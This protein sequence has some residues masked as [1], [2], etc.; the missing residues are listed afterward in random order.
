MDNNE[1]LNSILE[2]QKNF[3]EEMRS[4]FQS[5]NERFAGIDARFNEMDERFAGI[6]ERFNEMDERFDALNKNF[7]D[8]DIDKKVNKVDNEVGLLTSQTK[9]GRAHV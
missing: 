6:D 5:V 1:L 3:Q 7:I 8:I 4:E 2:Q 9:I